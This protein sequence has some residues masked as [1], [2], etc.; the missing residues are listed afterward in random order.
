M[1]RIEQ[2]GPGFGNQSDLLV[3]QEGDK[4]FVFFIS[5]HE[6]GKSSLWKLTFEPFEKTKT[7]PVKDA[8][9]GNLEIKGYKDH[10]YILN[11]GN[12]SKL[13]INKNSLDKVEMDFPFAINMDDEFNQMF[14]EAWGDLQENYYNQNFNGVNWQSIRDR[15]ASFLPQ[16]QTRNDFR[17]LLNDMMGELNSSHYG[18]STYGAD[19]KTYYK[20]TTASPGIVFNNQHPY[21]VD[22]VITDDCAILR[23]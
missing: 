3:T 9:G 1:D 4:T 20:T 11:H 12:I 5:N 15:Y 6:N 8:T 16:I 23:K 10:F 2:I 13:D 19:E 14:Y 7:E 21:L 18:F 22:H 17:V